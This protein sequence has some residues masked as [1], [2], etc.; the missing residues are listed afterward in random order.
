MNGDRA[1]I[2]EHYQTSLGLEN[3][4]CI[5]HGSQISVGS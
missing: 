5:L 1:G 2:L 3:E 4:I